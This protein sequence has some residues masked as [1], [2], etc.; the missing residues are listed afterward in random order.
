MGIGRE[1]R[2]K[3]KKN[4]CA[5]IVQDFTSGGAPC[6]KSD[7][8]KLLMNQSETISTGDAADLFR[9][10]LQEKK[11][12]TL[13]M[14]LPECAGKHYHSVLSPLFHWNSSHRCTCSYD[15]PRTSPVWLNWCQAFPTVAF[16]KHT[17]SIDFLT[18]YLLIHCTYSFPSLLG[19]LHIW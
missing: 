8:S 4:R 19:L 10:H 1:K 11:I 2:K 18:K 12:L 9:Q 16:K 6:E 7:L 3:E 17:H 5:Q 14:V 13:S 15:L